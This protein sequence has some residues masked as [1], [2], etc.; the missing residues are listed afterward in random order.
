MS[1]MPYTCISTNDLGKMVVILSV[2]AHDDEPQSGMAVTRQS[3]SSVYLKL[4]P[5]IVYEPISLRSPIPNRYHPLQPIEPGTT[6][7]SHV[8]I[9]GRC[10]FSF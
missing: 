8:E 2:N 3:A 4:S 10:V 7:S 9:E 6:L 1:G 5:S